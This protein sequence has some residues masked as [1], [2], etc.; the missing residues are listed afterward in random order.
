MVNDF[1]SENNIQSWAQERI[2]QELL[3]KLDVISNECSYISNTVASTVFRF[4]DV[5]IEL[6]IH[7]PSLSNLVPRFCSER[8]KDM[9]V[10][11]TS[12]LLRQCEGEIYKAMNEHLSLFRLQFCVNF[13][14]GFFLGKWKSGLMKLDIN[15]QILFNDL[16][17]NCFDTKILFT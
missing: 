3:F 1:D 15:T 12:F 9:V 2:R 4:I 16:N 8:K 17:F 13:F 11:C 10:V 7:R 5:C 6:Y 14:F